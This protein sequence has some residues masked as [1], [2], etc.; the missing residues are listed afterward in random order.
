MSAHERSGWRDQALSDRHRRWYGKNCPMV[1]LDFV[2]CE[3]DSGKPAAIVEYKH[4][5]R[6]REDFTHPT[7]QALAHLAN[8]AGIPFMVAYYQPNPW[9]FYVIP[10][11]ESAT[12]IYKRPRPLSEK[13]F[14]DSL[15]CIRTRVIEAEVTA[16]LDT[17]ESTDA[18][19]PGIATAAEV[20]FPTAEEAAAMREEIRRRAA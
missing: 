14:V 12:A 5:E 6:G 1:D 8:R 9:R 20:P 7:Y 4:V 15:Y 18:D 3:Y 11:N 17:G 2:A 13:R 19:W 16:H 10:M